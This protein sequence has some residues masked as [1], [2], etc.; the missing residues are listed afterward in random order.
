MNPMPRIT[1]ALALSLAAVAALPANSILDWN[2]EM[3]D[4]IRLSR[5]PPPQ[6]S[7]AL[8]VY[9]AAIYDAVNGIVGTHQHYALKEAAPAGA[10]PEAAAAEAARVTF[11]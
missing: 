1:A 10:D 6:A 9:H 11:L 4:A 8:G 3:L 5:T 7:Y 2:E